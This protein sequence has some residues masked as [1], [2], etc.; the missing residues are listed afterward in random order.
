VPTVFPSLL[1]I[2][3]VV[4]FVNYLETD[5]VVARLSS[6][7][8]IS[9][10]SSNIERRIAAGAMISAAFQ[11]IDLRLRRSSRLGGA[12]LPGT[13]KAALCLKER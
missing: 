1:S 13:V 7:L 8:V 9:T 6:D 5:R 2:S 3:S 11:A 12:N 10:I 4:P